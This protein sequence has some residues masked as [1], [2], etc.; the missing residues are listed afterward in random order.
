M[1]DYNRV[2]EGGGGR[3]NVLHLIIKT[4]SPQKYS[5]ILLLKI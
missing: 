1:E 2:M 4:K 3:S 5:E